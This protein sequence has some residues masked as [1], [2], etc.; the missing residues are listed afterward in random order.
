[1][2]FLGFHISRILPPSESATL[3]ILNLIVLVATI[4]LGYYAAK[5]F[6]YMRLGRLERGWMLVTGGAIFLSF[7]FLSLAI[8][9]LFS[10]NSNYFFYFDAFGMTLSIAGI[11]LMVLGLRSHYQVWTRRVDSRAPK[12]ILVKE[13]RSTEE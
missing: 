3:V 13:R 9:H 6:F 2:S 4:C 1:M 5:I 8:Q 12:P 10:R 11:I 7:A